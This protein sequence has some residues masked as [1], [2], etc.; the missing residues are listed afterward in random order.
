MICI[1]CGQFA[2]K[3]SCSQCDDTFWHYM[4]RRHIILSSFFA[5][6]AFV[7]FILFGGGFY[8]IPRWQGG[9]II[10]LA[11]CAGFMLTT[12]SQIYRR[13]EKIFK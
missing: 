8:V 5:A 3:E 10:A 7:A 11:V 4:K 9:A 1:K 13:E 12:L 6:A 2:G